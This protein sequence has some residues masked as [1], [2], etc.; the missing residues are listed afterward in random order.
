MTESRT[1]GM[2]SEK[3]V[4]GAHG[5]TKGK[6][7][8]ISLIPSILEEKIRKYFT[9][10]MKYIYKTEN[11]KIN[12]HMCVVCYSNLDESFSL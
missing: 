4:I 1:K 10:Y 7:C 3:Q 2:Y 8:T 12:Y 11:R 6:Q 5:K 9:N